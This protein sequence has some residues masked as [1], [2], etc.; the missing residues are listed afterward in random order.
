MMI[1]LMVLALLGLFWAFDELGDAPVWMNHW[2]RRHWWSFYY[3]WFVLV[4][5]CI[6]FWV[7]VAG[8]VF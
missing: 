1:Y 4:V 5:G 2:T 7:W 3:V 8:S 6:A